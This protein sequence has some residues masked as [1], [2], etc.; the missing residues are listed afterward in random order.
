[1]EGEG[2]AGT[3]VEGGGVAAVPRGGVVL[4]AVQA[5]PDPRTLR[6]AGARVGDG[7]PVAGD[8]VVEAGLV[9][10]LGDGRAQQ[11][12]LG[13]PLPEVEGVGLARALARGDLTLVDLVGRNSD[14]GDVAVS[15]H[16]D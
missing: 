12:A 3:R 9:L 14:A 2:A 16:R 5:H 13:N 8:V 6:E 10:A 15:A 11:D 7:D 1:G 4:R